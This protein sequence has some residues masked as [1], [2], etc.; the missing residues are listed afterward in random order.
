MSEEVGGNFGN[1]AFIT[2]KAVV[3]AVNQFNFAVLVNFFVT[4]AVSVGNDNI[5]RAV[6][7]ISAGPVNFSAVS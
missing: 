6:N 3:C 4:Q 5:A 7:L 2:D 1:A